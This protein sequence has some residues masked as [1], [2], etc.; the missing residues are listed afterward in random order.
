MCMYSA[1]YPQVDD[2]FKRVPIQ[3]DA[4]HIETVRLLN[5]LLER[6]KKLDERMGLREC[7]ETEESK[8]ALEDKIR[9]VL[10]GE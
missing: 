1:I 3:P 5:E 6:V 9:K 10:D 2:W 8:K 7:R 4:S